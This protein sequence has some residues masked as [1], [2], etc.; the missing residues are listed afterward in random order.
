MLLYASTLKSHFLSPY[1][2]L[3]PTPVAVQYKARTAAFRLLGL[4]VRIS[5]GHGYLS[6]VECCALSGRVLRD[7]LIPPPEEPYRVCVCVCGRACVSLRVIR[8]D[9]NPCTRIKT[10]RYRGPRA[11]RG[12]V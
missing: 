9:N 8:C 5:P 4:L 12:G 1:N 10:V 7:G 2:G 11:S 3:K 6:V